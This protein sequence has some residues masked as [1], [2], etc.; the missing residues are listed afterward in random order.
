V[1]TVLDS[2]RGEHIAPHVAL[3]TQMLPRSQYFLEGLPPIPHRLAVYL[4]NDMPDNRRS[5]PFVGEG[6][7][8][9]GRIAAVEFE[10]WPHRRAH[11]LALHV[12]GVP[13]NAQSQKPNKGRD[14]CVVSAGAA[15]SPLFRHE[16]DLIAARGFM[17]I[18]PVVK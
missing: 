8:N 15:R 9:V 6:K 4:Y 12:G 1:K 3:R 2:T 17:S 7:V 16:A 13:R 10:D 5:D 11:L 18:A 14:D